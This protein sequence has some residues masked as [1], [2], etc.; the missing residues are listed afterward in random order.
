LTV[1]VPTADVEPVRATLAPRPEQLSHLRLGVLENG[2]PNSDRLLRALV[3]ALVPLT[4]V[5]LLTWERKPAIGRLAPREMIDR[6]CA[7]SDLVITGVGDCAGCCSCSI[8]DAVELEQRGIPTAAI[9]TSEFVTAASLAA[10][11]AG[12]RGYEVA[13]IAHPLGL[14]TEAELVDRADSIINRV[15]KLLGDKFH[16][17]EERR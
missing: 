2:K 11:A 6:L 16:D 12:A 15:R 4:G 3:D 17:Q 13:V 7:E 5:E 8:A 9:C 10:A 14:C 1:L